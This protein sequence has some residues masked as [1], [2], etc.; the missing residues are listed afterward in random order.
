VFGCGAPYVVSLFSLYLWPLHIAVN[1]YLLVPNVAG[2]LS[3]VL[4]CF[5]SAISTTNWCNSNCLGAQLDSLSLSGPCSPS[6]PLVSVSLLACCFFL[7]VM[8]SEL[9]SSAKDVVGKSSDKS[10]RSSLSS[11][12]ALKSSVPPLDALGAKSWSSESLDDQIRSILE[13]DDSPRVTLRPEELDAARRAASSEVSLHNPTSPTHTPL[14]PSHAPSSSSSP[15]PRASSPQ[16][17]ST[18]RQ[19]S[20]SRKG[21]SRRLEFTMTDENVVADPGSDASWF[22]EQPSCTF[23]GASS[24]LLHGKLDSTRLHLTLA[25]SAL[26]YPH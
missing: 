25:L 20:I 16:S 5:L 15:H 10:S 7:L 12:D 19:R 4:R 17:D 21:A 26:R 11:N 24:A 18:T 14:S 23:G 6:H 13:A 9:W 2:F 22:V 3:T 1:L 8:S